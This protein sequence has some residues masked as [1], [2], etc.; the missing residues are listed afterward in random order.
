MPTASQSAGIYIPRRQL[1]G[2]YQTRN[3]R[4]VNSPSQVDILS[5]EPY[6]VVKVLDVDSLV[7][8]P[9]K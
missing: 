6:S 5:D 3:H 7:E 9:T 4:D 1:T 8:I 2:D